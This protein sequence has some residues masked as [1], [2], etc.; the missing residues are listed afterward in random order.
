MRLGLRAL[1]LLVASGSMAACAAITGLDGIQED[2][3]FP[4]LC[5]D[6]AAGDDAPS[7]RET[8]A[9]EAMAEA[10]GDAV[11]EV[12]PDALADGVAE[13][14]AEAVA[15]AVADVSEEA[16]SRDGS[17]DALAE[18][19]DADAAP[20]EVLAVGDLRVL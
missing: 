16:W 11:A 6:A 4:D 10:S 14:P 3:C 12:G 8:S 13:A 9:P 2:P 19:G 5:N 18:T 20:P 7:S 17:A 1:S 15:D